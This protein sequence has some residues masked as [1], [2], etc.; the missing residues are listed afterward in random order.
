MTRLACLRAAFTIACCALGC[1]PDRLQAVE[2]RSDSLFRDLLGHW[3]FDDAAGTSARD[4]SGNGLNGTLTGGTWLTDGRF[5]GALHLASG[6]F[7]TVSKGADAGSSF[8]VSAWVRLPIMSAPTSGKWTTIVSTEN[9]GGWEVNVDNSN[10]PELAL[11]FGF[12]KGGNTDNYE[13]HSCAGA[14]LNR[15]SHIAGVSDTALKTF[16]VYRDGKLCFSTSTTYKIR[17]G[18]PFLTIGAWPLGGR[19]LIGDV[20]DIAIWGRA[21]EPAEIELVNERKVPS[22]LEADK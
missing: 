10:Y 21:L 20:D 11:H 4:D 9:S 18:S 13:G 3:G 16:T 8:T 19:Y 6:E 5:G 2:L 14:P 12:W 22:S 7:V 1:A 15:W 17:P